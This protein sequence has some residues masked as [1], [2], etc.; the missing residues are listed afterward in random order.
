MEL[1]Q[2]YLLVSD[3]ERS[4]AF[5]E[6]VLDL[7]VAERS[8]ERVAFET[9]ECELVVE[10]DFDEETFSAFGLR[11]PGDDRGRGAFFVFDVEDV[12][13]VYDRAVEWGATVPTEPRA[14]D[15]GRKICLVEDPDGYVLEVGRPL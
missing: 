9:G 3:V 4:A 14:V 11:P 13:A 12:D 2:T 6:T 5:Y 1:T 8:D 10:E 7:T 15:W